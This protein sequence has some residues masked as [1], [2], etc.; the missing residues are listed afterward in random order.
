MHGVA[1]DDVAA[2]VD[3]GVT[4]IVIGER[5]AARPVADDVVRDEPAN[6]WD[7]HET[8]VAR[9]R[10]QPRGGVAGPTTFVVNPVHLR[11]GH[12]SISQ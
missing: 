9:Q 8:R 4:Q 12:V 11:C 2:E 6:P 1:G 10:R 7:R 5:H 3:Q